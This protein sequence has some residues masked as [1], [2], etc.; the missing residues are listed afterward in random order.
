[1]T[2]AP[3]AFPLSW[4]VA[5]PRYTKPRGRSNFHGHGPPSEHGYRPK[6]GLTVAEAS[7]RLQRELTLLPAFDVV[8]SS[9]VPLRRDGL[10][11]S[12]TSNPLDPGVAVYFTLGKRR[13]AGGDPV[14]LA[15][16]RFSHP[17]DNLAAVAAHVAASRAIERYGVGRLRELFRGFTALPEHATAIAPDDWRAVL[18]N[19]QTLDEAEAS[20]RERMKVAHPD[21]GGSQARAAALNAAIALA[22]SAYAERN[23]ASAGR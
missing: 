6:R 21:V 11:R 4:P 15:C 2:D 16:D 13:S 1:M 10:P 3:L 8:V 23:D 7:E 9:N 17:A 5:K 18:G 20:Y 19:P 22:R 12:D 14:V